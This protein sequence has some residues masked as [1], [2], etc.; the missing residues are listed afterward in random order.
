[1]RGDTSGF[2]QS[3]DYLYRLQQGLQSQERGAA[4][5]G[6]FMG[7]GADADRIALAQ[8]IA[9]QGASDYWAKLAGQA[10]QGYQAAANLG[11]LGANMAGNIG[12]A[13][14]NIGQARASAYGARSDANAQLA[15]GLG[16]VFNNWYSQNR[17]NNPGGT[18]FYLGNQP[19]RG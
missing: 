17:A 6:G 5:R 4:A 3:P 16:G 9:A 1:M 10:G 13:Y 12:N 14:G 2:D 15:A 19:G 7:G 8:G 18:G 11:S